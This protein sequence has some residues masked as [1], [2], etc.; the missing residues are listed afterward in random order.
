[1]P[2][3]G[4][5]RYEVSGDAD[6]APGSSG[7]LG[8]GGTGGVGEAS[9]SI[10]PVHFGF[11]GGGLS[12]GGGYGFSDCQNS[13]TSP[14]GGGGGGSSYVTRTAVCRPTFQTGV[15][16][17]DGEVDIAYNPRSC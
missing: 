8:V 2:H 9:R 6:G 10:G 14:A 12:G 7:R 1:M 4:P 15:R 17:G 11:G 16:T 13:F 5:N 3:R